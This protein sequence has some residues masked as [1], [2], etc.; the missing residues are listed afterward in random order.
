MESSLS[1]SLCPEMPLNSAHTRFPTAYAIVVIHLPSFCPTDAHAVERRDRGR[2]CTQQTCMQLNAA[3]DV[4]EADGGLPDPAADPQLDG[5]WRLVSLAIFGSWWC[6][7]IN[8]HHI[9]HYSG[10]LCPRIQHIGR[11]LNFDSSLNA[12][13][14]SGK[15]L[16]MLSPF[17]G[18]HTHSQ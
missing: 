13:K 16:R 15:S 9:K 10:P 4:L 1:T 11:E 8:T 18:T 6:F 2:E 12:F 3:V 5:L 14:L 7:G 17:S